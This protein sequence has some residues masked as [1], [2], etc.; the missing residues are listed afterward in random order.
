MSNQLKTYTE[1][2]YPINTMKIRLNSEPNISKYSIKFFDGDICVNSPTLLSSIFFCINGLE[3]NENIKYENE[4]NQYIIS[5]DKDISEFDILLLSFTVS[6][7]ISFNNTM[8]N[9]QY[10]FA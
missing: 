7:E 5:I 9:V 8:L 2:F 3:D 6:S 1:T 10:S 4:T